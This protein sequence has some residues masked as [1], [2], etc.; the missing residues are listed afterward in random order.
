MSEEFVSEELKPCGALTGSAALATGAPGLP[1]GFFWRGER[2]MITAV[3]ESWREIGPAREGGKARYLRRHWYRLQTDR[4]V[5]LT[6]YFERTPRSA[7]ARKERWWLY[8][9][10]R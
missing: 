1:E 7:R 3:V 5:C 9:L 8:S 10:Q 2:Y 6:V 4:G